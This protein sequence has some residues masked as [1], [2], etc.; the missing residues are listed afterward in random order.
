MPW[1]R[2]KLRSYNG[3]VIFFALAAA[4]A[5]G[6]LASLG[7][8]L[9]LEHGTELVDRYRRYKSVTGNYSESEIRAALEKRGMKAH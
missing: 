3:R 1:K 8:E 2:K 9:L 7:G 6:I 4:A 5:C